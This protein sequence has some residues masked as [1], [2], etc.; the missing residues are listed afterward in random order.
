MIMTTTQLEWQISMKML[1][2][3][4]ES[5]SPSKV[6]EY[7]CFVKD[8]RSTVGKL[9]LGAV[10]YIFVGYSGTQKGYIC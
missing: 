4:N 3:K 10:K 6:F 2:G 8:D 9:N 1:Q 5:I 7:V